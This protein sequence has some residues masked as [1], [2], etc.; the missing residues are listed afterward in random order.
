MLN[1]QSCN[2]LF[3]SFHHCYA[4]C[5]E[6]LNTSCLAK[7]AETNSA[8]PDQTADCC[9]DEHLVNSIPDNQHFL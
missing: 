1:D 7:K 2:Y 4:R 9:S 6:I 3:I 8:D 5:F